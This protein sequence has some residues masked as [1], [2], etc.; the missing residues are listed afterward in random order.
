MES[1]E[2]NMNPKYL[3]D[4]LVVGMQT[5]INKKELKN[6][7][8]SLAI[9]SFEELKNVKYSIK[10]IGKNKYLFEIH[11]GSPKLTYL[12]IIHEELFKN[13]KT[14]IIL[15]TNQKNIKVFKRSD[16]KIEASTLVFLKNNEEKAQVDYKSKGHLK[17]IKKDGS[18]ILYLASICFVVTGIV[19]SGSFFS[20]YYMLNADYSYNPVYE[21]VLSPIEYIDKIDF[22]DYSETTYM[23]NIKYKNKKWSHE[24]KTIK[25][26][27][28]K[29][30]NIQSSKENEILEKNNVEELNKNNNVVENNIEVK[31]DIPVIN[32][33]DVE[34]KIAE[35][36]EEK[37][38]L[39]NNK[40]KET[41]D[42]NINDV[43]KKEINIDDLPK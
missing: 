6:Y 3:P 16:F 31:H 33:S 4:A 29:K 35:L 12:N 40:M 41:T 38:S 13:N 14:E 18:E 37:T 43:T 7:I 5:D 24:I 2:K 1:N 17:N 34:N 21:K 42:L 15:K 32:Q 10:N 22:K 11:N 19:A 23:K 39:E 25:I 36:N 8:E 20:K 30:E 26:D 28:P 9:A 27:K